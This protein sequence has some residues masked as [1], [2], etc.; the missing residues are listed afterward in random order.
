MIK[1]AAVRE[2]IKNEEI[3]IET[4]SSEEQVADA[5]TKALPLAQFLHLWKFMLK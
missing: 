5:L 4:V 3:Q 1:A 2:A